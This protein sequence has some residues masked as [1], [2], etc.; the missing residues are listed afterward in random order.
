M[1]SATRVTRSNNPDGVLLGSSRK[2]E[3]GNTLH[4]YRVTHGITCKVQH[5]RATSKQGAIN[6]AAYEVTKL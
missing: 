4:M 6:I 3:A 5:I 1:F 2:D